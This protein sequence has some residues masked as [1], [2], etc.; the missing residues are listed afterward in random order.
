MLGPRSRSGKRHAAPMQPGPAAPTTEVQAHRKA[1]APRWSRCSWC[2]GRENRPCST[3]G[4][5]GVEGPCV[6]RLQRAACGVPSAE[7]VPQLRGVLDDLGLL[8]LL[9][10]AV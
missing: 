8:D 1:P 5:R 9:V 7:H 2:C 6:D 10:E 3:A 4:E